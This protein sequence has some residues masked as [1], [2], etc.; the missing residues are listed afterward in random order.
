MGPWYD[1]WLAGTATPPG[2]EAFEALRRRAAAA[3]NRA[4]ER[5]PPVLVVAH[6]SLFRALRAE[7]KLPA[8]IRTPNGLPLLCAPG[9]MPDDSWRLTALAS[10]LSAAAR[11]AAP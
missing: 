6:G 8:T 3:M 9:E 2:A 5:T 1:E 4:V 11:D 7:M 10:D